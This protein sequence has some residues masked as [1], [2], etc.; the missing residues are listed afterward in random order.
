MYVY[1]PFL[2]LADSDL[3]TVSIVLLSPE[4]HIVV[5]IWYAVF[6]DCSVP[7]FRSRVSSES[8]RCSE[9]GLQE[10]QDSGSLTF[11]SALLLESGRHQV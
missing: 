1:L 4:S 8:L 3:S 6:A 2:S 7:W 10:T 5:I 9:V 11:I